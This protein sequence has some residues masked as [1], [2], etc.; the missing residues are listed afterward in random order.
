M[1]CRLEGKGIV[2]TGCTP[3]TKW[4]DIAVF[5]LPP[6]ASG[7]RETKYSAVF[8][9]SWDDGSERS[10]KCNTFWLHIFTTAALQRYIASKMFSL[11]ASLFGGK[12]ASFQMQFQFL[13]PLLCLIPSLT[14]HTH[15]ASIQRWKQWDCSSV[16]GSGCAP[17]VSCLLAY[18]HFIFIWDLWRYLT[19][20]E[21]SCLTSSSSVLQLSL[22]ELWVRAITHHVSGSGPVAWPTCPHSPPDPSNRNGWPLHTF[23]VRLADGVSSGSAPRFRVSFKC[24]T[25]WQP[26]LWQQLDFSRKSAF[27]SSA[28]VRPVGHLCRHSEWCRQ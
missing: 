22:S 13:F 17:K 5:N 3:G 2:S 24:A 21:A 12:R 18:F 19:Q 8:C 28:W 15:S 27:A 7:S 4:N 1:R 26:L 20:G 25:F 9:P 10:N 14:Q 16:L 6:K 23:Q 11:T